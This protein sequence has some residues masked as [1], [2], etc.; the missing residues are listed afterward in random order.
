MQISIERLESVMLS[1]GVTYKQLSLTCFNKDCNFE[2]I[3]NRHKGDLPKNVISKL[4]VAL[5]CSEEYLTGTDNN[6]E[7]KQPQLKNII[8]EKKNPKNKPI[9]N[10]YKDISNIRIDRLKSLIKLNGFSMNT[11]N[12][13][14]MNYKQQLNNITHH[15]CKSI[16]NNTFKWLL[17]LLKCDEDYL[18]GNSDR[19]NR[20][21]VPQ[22]R[23]IEI[24]F[25]NRPNKVQLEFDKDVSHE[26]VAKLLE[27]SIPYTT[28]MYYHRTNISNDFLK[29]LVKRI[30]DINKEHEELFISLNIYPEFDAAKSN[31]IDEPADTSDTKEE[32]EQEQLNNDISDICDN[33]QDI[34]IDENIQEDDNDMIDYSQY[35]DDKSAKIHKELIEYITENVDYIDMNTC[36]D[37][38][39]IM[40][41]IIKI[42][43]KKNLLIKNNKDVL[44]YFKDISQLHYSLNKEL[45]NM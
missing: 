25:D 31:K 27:I 35:D 21:K 15:V 19:T 32:I 13:V 33:D 3:V 16:D 39:S 2:S 36:M 42:N 26:D 34:I 10:G 4:T 8:V 41:N 6:V 12:M 23:D 14:C 7:L 43:E 22:L 45:E 29:Y 44:D 24:D 11:F 17:Y 9:R 1:Q 38:I 18:L 37:I 30:D 20:D 40:N 28:T 5:G